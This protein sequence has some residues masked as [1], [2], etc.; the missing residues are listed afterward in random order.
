MSFA[1]DTNGVL[2]AM[3]NGIKILWSEV[4]LSGHELNEVIQKVEEMGEEDEG[5]Q[6]TQL[7]STCGLYDGTSHLGRSTCL[8]RIRR[9]WRK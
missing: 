3:K 9:E 6:R 5:L 8:N 1:V 4:R 7:R 2:S